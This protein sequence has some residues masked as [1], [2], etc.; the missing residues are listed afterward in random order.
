MDLGSP[1][2]KTTDLLESH[3]LKSRFLVL[4]LTAGPIRER[5]K[6]IVSTMATMGIVSTMATI[7]IVSTM[8]TMAIA[9]LKGLGIPGNCLSRPEDALQQV[10]SSQGLGPLAQS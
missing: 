5:L 2:L 3:P 7:G 6:A 9:K 8:A 10:Q 4:D 1:P